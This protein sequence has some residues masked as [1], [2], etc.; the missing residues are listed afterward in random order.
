MEF[1][2]GVLKLCFIVLLLILGYLVIKAA[3][4]ILAVIL[5]VAIAI[6]I[7]YLIHVEV[8]KPNEPSE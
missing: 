6:L 4:V 3:V 2:V 8:K 7:A 5:A 1:L